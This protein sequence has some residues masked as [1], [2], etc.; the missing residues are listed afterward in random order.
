M[1]LPEHIVLIPDGNRRWAKKKGLAAFLGHKQGAE[2]MGDIIKAARELKISCLTFWGSSLDN[3][4]KRPAEEVDFLFEVFREYFEKL[5]K[6]E[7]IYEDSVRVEILGRWEELFPEKAKKPMREII[8]KTKNHKN[9]RLTFL[10]A[11][12]GVDEMA[13]AI[14]KIA[15]LKFKN[16][17]L[18]ID[19]K[20]IKD[21]LWTK[22]LPPVDLVIRT[23][24]AGDPHW[25][26]GLM[27]W[28]TADAQL[29]F[30]DTLFPDFSPAEFKKAVE[31]YSGKERRFGK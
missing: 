20:L 15:E 12:S 4:A 7:E 30:T 16:P 9:H 13:E 18:K 25:S 10:M 8:E 28:D 3:I 6:S 29:Y 27:M 26:S 19:E 31:Q 23:G 1:N 2:I 11:Y 5:V 22:D 24:S 17:D 21:S 14:K